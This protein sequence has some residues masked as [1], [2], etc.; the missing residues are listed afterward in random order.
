[1]FSGRNPVQR[2]FSSSV[3]ILAAFASIM[4]VHLIAIVGHLLLLF[5]LFDMLSNMREL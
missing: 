1:M 4:S 3:I 5:Y 2:S